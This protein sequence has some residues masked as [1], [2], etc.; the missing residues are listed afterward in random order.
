MPSLSKQKNINLNKNSENK[1]FIKINIL[2]KSMVRK[3]KI[4]TLALLLSFVFALTIVS[5]AIT[6]NT[7]STAGDTVTGTFVFN[8]T[9]DLTNTENCSWATTADSIFNTTINVTTGQLV[10]N[11][12]FDTTALTDAEDTTL[13]VTCTNT[14][15]ATDIDTLL[16]NVDNTAPVCS[17]SKDRE[18]VDFQDGVGIVTTQ[19][20]TDTTDLTY[21]WT[22]YRSDSTSSATSTDSAPTFSGS[23]FDQ[24]DEFILGLIVTD[25]ASQSTGCTNQTITVSGSNGGGLSGA[26]ITSA[27]IQENKTELIVGGIIFLIVVLGA[28]AVLFVINSKK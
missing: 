2:V 12:S 26:P 24:P 19:A 16:I 13:T 10:F 15:A 21:A 17:F 23:A 18:I 11:V 25:E 14:T 3:D 7:P 1:T 4:F 27:F 20:S 8:V 22:L 5:A 9:T 6:F 28:V